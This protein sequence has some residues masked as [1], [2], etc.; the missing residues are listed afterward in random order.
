MNGI[1]L[2]D[3]PS[4]PT[5]HDVVDRVRRKL[6]IKKVGHAGTLDPI[7]TG[8]LVLGIGKGTRIL[9]YFLHADKVYR[10]Q[11]KLG[12]V[13]ETFDI[14]GEIKEEHPCNVTESEVAQALKSLQGEFLQVP[15]A[16]SAR[17]YKGRKLY[18]LAREGKIIRL[19]PRRV[20]VH[21]VEVIQVDLQENLVEALF[22]VS[23]GTYIRS[24]CMELGYRLGCGAVMNGLT[25]IQQGPFK[26]ESAVK[27]EDVSTEKITP[28]NVALGWM[29]ALVVN[30]ESAERV[31]NGGQ[32]Y[33]SQVIEVV[34]DFSKDADIRIL[35]PSG[36]LLAVARS[37]RTSKFIKTL[38][39]HGRRD[40]VA[41]LKKVLA[42][43]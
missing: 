34:G 6:G 5:S 42:E 23:S 39:S 19:P 36:E 27:L 20:F 31:K 28:I 14:T 32:I 41:K 9:E 8:L 10:A 21:K 29:P 38:K 33:T 16:Y 15:P 43:K 12:I 2:I 17:K 22:K 7:A 13:T 37:E 24:L 30:E 11:I 35:D 3:K 1:L 40:R 18:E 26:L 4:G 25:R